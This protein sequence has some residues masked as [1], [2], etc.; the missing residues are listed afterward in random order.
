[1][2]EV[3]VPQ[4]DWPSHIGPEK[5]EQLMVKVREGSKVQVKVYASCDVCES[6]IMCNLG[7]RNVIGGGNDLRVARQVGDGSTVRDGEPGVSET[8]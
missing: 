4:E 1:M 7:L 2:R 3:V 8:V 6:C 5:A